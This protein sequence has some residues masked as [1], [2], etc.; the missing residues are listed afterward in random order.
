MKIINCLHKVA[1]S[2][3]DF[4]VRFWDDQRN[5]GLCPTT[6]S[7]K[8]LYQDWWKECKHCPEN[9]AFIYGI[10]FFN[11]ATGQ[12]YCAEVNKP[13]EFTFEDLM[14]ITEDVLGL[15]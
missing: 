4:S 2:P 5:E 9:G 13:F 15:R 3:D 1:E 14:R 10:E 7:L 8:T 11:N 6:I 12:V